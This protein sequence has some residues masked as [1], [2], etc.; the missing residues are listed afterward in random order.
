MAVCSTGDAYISGWRPDLTD[1]ASLNPDTVLLSH[2]SRECGT[3]EPQKEEHPC[4]QVQRLEQVKRRYFFRDSIWTWWLPAWIF[5]IEFNIHDGW[6][7]PAVSGTPQDMDKHF[8]SHLL[9]HLT[10]LIMFWLLHS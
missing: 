5:A 8:L 3:A 6:P 9:L 1:K 2:S 10:L 7:L 4:P